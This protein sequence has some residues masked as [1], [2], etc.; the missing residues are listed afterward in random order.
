MTFDTICRGVYLEGLCADADT[1]WVSDPV[2]GGLR[3]IDASGISDSWLPE[4]RWIGGLVPNADGRVLLSGA[5][6]ILWLDG[7]TG[8][9]GV[10]IDSCDGE[11]LAGVNEMVADGRGGLYFGSLDAAAVARGAAP[12]PASLYHLDIDG[13]VRELCRGLR[14]SNGIALSPDLR[15][16]YHCETFNGL[17]AY[18]VAEDGSLGEGRRLLKKWDCDGITVDADGTL[19]VAG[20]AS[21]AITCLHPDGSL[22]EE[23]AI[24]G[25]G[26]SNVRFGGADRRDLY[27]T[28]VPAGIAEQ[29]KNGIWPTGE[30]SLLCKARAAV[31][32]LP[33]RCADFKKR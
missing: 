31:P 19:W 5:G 30:E 14:F 4:R 22:K 10:L 24:P 15:T 3:R 21:P 7:A 28:S 2:R 23:I 8:A 17:F 9:S 11:P 26:A 16:L 12:A 20:C 25:G 18:P 32:G 29:M 13:R 6:G 1:V 33:Y 27:V